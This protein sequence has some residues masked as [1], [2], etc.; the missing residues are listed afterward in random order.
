MRDLSQKAKFYG[1]EKEWA[2]LE[3]QA[4]IDTPAYA[5][6]TA[7]FLV[8]EMKIT[9]PKDAVQLAA[10]KNLAYKEGHYKG[11][12]LTGEFQGESVS[13]AK[14]KIQNAFYESGDAFPYAEPDGKFVSRSGDECVVAYLGQWFLNYGSDDLPWQEKVIKFVSDYLNTFSLET[15]NQLIATIQWLNRWA[16]ARSYGLGSK[17]PWDHNF[18][19]ESLTDST[20]YQAYYTISHILHADR[21]GKEVGAAKVRPEQMIDEVWD[22]VFAQRIIDE[23]LIKRSGIAKSTLQSMRREF[24]YWYPLD[25]SVIGKDLVL[26]H[27]IFSLYTHLALFPPLA[28]EH[29]VKWTSAS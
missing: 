29:S 19:I 25:M 26:N 1:I 21:F 11:K 28:K 6:L 5:G 18:V 10:A 14:G 27:V 23:G 4:I 3:V 12:M 22:C 9:S 7:A 17:L 16:C 20:I 8:N 2:E 24:D 13:S 15:K